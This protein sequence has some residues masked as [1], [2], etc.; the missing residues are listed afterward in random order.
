MPKGVETLALTVRAPNAAAETAITKNLRMSGLLER[1]QGNHHLAD[2]MENIRIL[3]GILNTTL[4]YWAAPRPIINCIGK[5][6][7]CDAYIYCSVR[8]LRGSTQISP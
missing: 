4:W 1:M 7:F 3:S 2:G 8:K 6:R 5:R